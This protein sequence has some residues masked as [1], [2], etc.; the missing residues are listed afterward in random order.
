MRSL[1]SGVW[2]CDGAQRTWKENKQEKSEERCFDLPADYRTVFADPAVDI[3]GW[4]L[5]QRPRRAWRFEAR[6]LRSCP[7]TRRNV[8]SARLCLKEDGRKLQTKKAN[9]RQR[10]TGEW[11]NFHAAVIQLRGADNIRVCSLIALACLNSLGD[12]SKKK[13]IMLIQQQELLL[14]WACRFA[15]MKHT[16]APIWESVFLFLCLSYDTNLIWSRCSSGLNVALQTFM[17]WKKTNKQKKHFRNQKWRG[18]ME[19]CWWNDTVAG[20]TCVT[21]CEQRRASALG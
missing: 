14:L 6:A 15:I 21:H 11:G 9:L 10:A 8:C 2:V 1:P 20:H 18:E 5:F 13:K 3:T 7:P 12:L 4:W 19:R 17:L 16:C